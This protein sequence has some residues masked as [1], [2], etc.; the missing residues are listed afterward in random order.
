MRNRGEMLKLVAEVAVV[1]LNHSA[2][3]SEDRADF[4]EGLGAFL[5]TRES[6]AARYAAT[7]I[8]E[9]SRAQREF[10][11]ALEVQKGAL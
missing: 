7:C 3:S 9:C 5:A 6:E 2:L 1:G 4:Y 8:R 10:L 11:A